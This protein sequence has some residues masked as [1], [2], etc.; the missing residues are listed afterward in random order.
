MFHDFT[1]VDREDFREEGCSPSPP[2]PPVDIGPIPTRDAPTDHFRE[3]NR[4]ARLPSARSKDTVARDRTY[5]LRA[6]ERLTLTELG[7]F[8]LISTED[9]ARHTYQGHRQEMGQDVRNLLR[10]GL[11]RRETFERPDGSPRQM[12]TLTKE[13]HRLIRANRLVGDSQSIYDGFRKPKEAAHDAD[14]YRLY[15]K[16][17]ARIEAEGGTNLRVVLD[18]ELQKK[19]NRDLAVWGAEAREQIASRHSLQMVGEKIPVPDL[20]IEYQTPEGE[21][22][23]VDL[24]LVTEHYRPGQLAEKARAGF[25]LYAPRSETGRLRG[26]LKRQG[27]TSGILSL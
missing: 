12:L 7:R 21:L 24:E 23:H 15:Q 1:A 19:L 3:T 22:A 8:R 10:Q 20:R 16:V 5:R 17:A 2:T 14:I 13:G 25:S 11:I 18:W 27:L 6:S 4:P 26:V 9:L